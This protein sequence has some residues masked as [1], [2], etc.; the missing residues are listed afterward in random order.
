MRCLRTTLAPTLILA[1]ALAGCG[2]SDQVGDTPP[3]PGLVD[4]LRTDAAWPHTP[5]PTGVALLDA[6]ETQGL[7][8]MPW[9]LLALSRASITIQYV[10]G[11]G[12]DQAAGAYRS[13]SGSRVLIGVY[14]RQVRPEGTACTT[15]AR[16]GIGVLP[17]SRPLGSRELVH[18]TVAGAEQGPL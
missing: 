14:S 15:D 10:V 9:H 5:A 3:Q 18:V 1:A 17:L 7:V 2:G 16:V 8:S 6:R 11:G 4:P 13:E 12:C